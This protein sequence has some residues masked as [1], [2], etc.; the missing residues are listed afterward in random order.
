MQWVGEGY[1]KP[2][3]ALAFDNITFAHSKIAGLV[4]LSQE[5]ARL[6]D[7]ACEAVIRSDLAAAVAQFTDAAFLDPTRAATD[8]SPASITNGALEIISTGD[9]AAAIES[10]LKLLL[11]SVAEGSNLVSPYLIMKPTTALA[12]ATV[13]DA[14]GDRLFPLLGVSGGSIWGVPVLTSPNVPGSNDSPGDHLVIA[15]DASEILL[16]DAG[17]ELSSSDQAT[18]QMDT[19]PDSPA[20]AS[21]N[22]VSLWQHDLLGIIAVRYVRWA[23]RRDTAVAFLRGFSLT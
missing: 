12:L 23:R 15:L 1:V 7:P 17:V 6:S 10:D 8:I 3:G 2:A 9:T 22:L 11:A 20:T 5:L 14:T 21:T 19:A 13:R 16:A 18:V 4:V